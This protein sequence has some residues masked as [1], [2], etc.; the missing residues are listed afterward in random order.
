MI[1]SPSNI[2]EGL[3]LMI[4]ENQEEINSLIRVYNRKDS[5]HLFKGMRKTLPVTSFPSL[6]MEATSGGM[7]WVTTSKMN[8]EYS[9]DCVLTI[10]CG[11]HNE[12]G[13]EYI[14]ERSRKIVQI[15]N[16]PQNMTWIIPNEYQDKDKTPVYCQ[17]SDVRSIEYSSTK[18]MSIRVARWTVTCRV[19]ESFPHPTNL[20]GPAKVD[21]KEDH[22]PGK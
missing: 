7:E 3:I 18:D 11:N 5:L 16:Y 15:F 22:I 21:W 4:K 9:I 2:I 10:N 12:L 1:T 6:E 8:G 14:C 19:L 13:L 17:Y 20:L